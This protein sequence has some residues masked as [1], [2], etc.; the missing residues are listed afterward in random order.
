MRRSE[1]RRACTTF[2]ESPTLHA[3]DYR[4]RLGAHSNLGYADL[5]FMCGFSRT[6]SENPL[7][8]DAERPMPS[9]LAAHP[10]DGCVRIILVRVVIIVVVVV[11]V[12]PIAKV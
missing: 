9:G 2:V 8:E 7:D 5:D 6:L 1:P 11:F 10:G 3:E 4:L 12:E